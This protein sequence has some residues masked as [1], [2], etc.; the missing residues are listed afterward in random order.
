VLLDPHSAVAFAAAWDFIK[1]DKFSYAHMVVLATGHPAREAKLVE[2]V[3]GQQLP[4]PGK[5]A[6]LQNE[7]EPIAVIEPHLGV[8][9]GLLAS[10]L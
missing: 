7:T 10:C 4:L 5:F 6:L 9:E 8:L 2:S 1:S 3:T